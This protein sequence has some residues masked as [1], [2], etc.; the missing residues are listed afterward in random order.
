MNYIKHDYEKA[1]IQ[2]RE[3]LEIYHRLAAKHSGTYEPNLAKET[4][5]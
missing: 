3:V 5:P 2:C 1:E 4:T